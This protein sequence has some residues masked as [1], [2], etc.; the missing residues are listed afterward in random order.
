MNL[1]NILKAKS[2]S[3]GEL[4]A[5]SVPTKWE[6]A[7]AITAEEAVPG[8][9]PIGWYVWVQGGTYYGLKPNQAQ[10][11]L[12]A[13]SGFQTLS[14]VQAWLGVSLP[15]DFTQAEKARRKAA[16]EAAAPKSSAYMFFQEYQAQQRSEKNRASAPT[17]TRPPKRQRANETHVRFTD[18]EFQCLQDRVA[19]SC[20]PQ[21]AFMRQAI[22]T[23]EIKADPHREIL[24]Q[25]IRGMNAKLKGIRGDCGKV[26]GLL[27][28][29]IKPNEEQKAMSPEEWD[30]LIRIIHELIKLQKVIDKTMEEINVYFS[31]EFQ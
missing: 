26:G 12:T 18:E 6:F 22:L 27:K 21:S 15:D 2:A 17:T 1:L 9:L 19:S 8:N 11:G 24:L 7:K 13:S 29:A 23:G 14:D 3:E 10:V 28:K 31:D 30:N 5:P 16:D 20:L 4:S 25:D